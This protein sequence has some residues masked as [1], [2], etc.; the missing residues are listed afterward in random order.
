[1]DKILKFENWS[2]Q[3]R[4]IQGA[5][6]IDEMARSERKCPLV[7]FSS[8]RQS[9]LYRDLL[10]LGFREVNTFGQDR[11]EEIMK[12]GGSPIQ[13][14]VQ[15]QGE[16]QGNL[17]FMHDRLYPGSIIRLQWKGQVPENDPAHNTFNLKD[18]KTHAIW[19]DGVKDPRDT[20]T[21]VSGPKKDYKYEEYGLGSSGDPKWARYC[22]TYKDYENRIEFLIK[23]LLS[24][25]GF[26]NRSELFNSEGGIEIIKRKLEENPENI[27]KLV[28]V[29]ESLKGDMQSL[30]NLDDLGFF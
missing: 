18:T 14:Q 4:N 30:K 13:G 10:S 27:K 9:Q 28:G 6:H 8:V 1:M 7:D 11:V 29:P 2:S 5:R 16:K 3:M 24:N 19:I 21:V 23:M 26:I 25:D 22:P 17:R 12:L 20:K 15:Y